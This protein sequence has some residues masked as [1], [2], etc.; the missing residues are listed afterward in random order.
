MVWEIIY[1]TKL[2]YPYNA[3]TTWAENKKEAPT[4]NTPYMLVHDKISVVKR[5][6]LKGT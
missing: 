6:L 3:T 4:S 1:K 2:Q 5:L